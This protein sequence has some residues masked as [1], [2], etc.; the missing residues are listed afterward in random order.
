MTH[1]AC[2]AGRPWLLSVTHP[3]CTPQAPVTCPAH[4]RVNPLDV[5]Q[6]TQPPDGRGGRVVYCGHVRHGNSQLAPGVYVVGVCDHASNWLGVLP[7]C[8]SAGGYTTAVFAVVVGVSVCCL[9]GHFFPF[10]WFSETYT[11][12]ATPIHGMYR[13]FNKAGIA[14]NEHLYNLYK[15]S[16]PPRVGVWFLYLIILCITC[17]GV[18]KE[19]QNPLFSI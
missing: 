9:C 14:K 10:F 8:P 5:E 2:V 4:K 7:A 15:M 13:Y 17:I 11:A 18:V 12:Y 6:G 3:R 19:G 1:L 16:F